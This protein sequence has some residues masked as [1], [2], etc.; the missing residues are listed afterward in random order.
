M[1]RILVVDDHTVLR[2]GIRSILELESDMRVVGEAVSG[3]E[4][5]KKVEE[6]RPDFILMD[7]NLPGKNGIEGD[8]PREKSVSELPCS[9]IDDV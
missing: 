1:I 7:I 9:Y 4:V 3:E 2:D 8:V 6:Y 5:L